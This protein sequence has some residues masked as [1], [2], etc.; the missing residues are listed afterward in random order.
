MTRIGTNPTR[1]KYSKYKPARVTAAVITYIPSLDGYFKQRL[2]ILKFNLTSLQQHTDVPHDLLIFDNASCEPV[3][4][5]LRELRDAE[6]LDYLVLSPRNLGKIGAFKIIFNLAPGEVIAYSDDDIYFY[7]GWLEAQM[8][9]LEQFPNV[10]MVSGVPVRNASNYAVKTMKKLKSGN[11]IGVDIS[12]EK[13]IPDEW[14]ADW[15]SS[16]GRDPK[17]HLENTKDHQDTILSAKGIKAVAFA[18]HFQFIGWKD[19]LVKALP[20]DWS[21]RLMGQMVE[22]DEAVDQ[23]GYLRLSTTDRY[24]RHIGNTIPSDLKEDALKL[25]ISALNS[26]YRRMNRKHWILFIPGMGRLLWS[27]YDKIFRIL[28]GVE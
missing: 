9:L 28:H 11:S 16:T 18:N 4:D 10:G 7:P 27:L 3:V 25:E 8:T 17:E 21:G 19:A 20:E 24:T 15:A 22:F 2:E 1:G 12:Y 26:G 5:Y 23:Q 14:E 6:K 13:I